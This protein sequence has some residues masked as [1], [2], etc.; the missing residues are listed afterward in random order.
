MSKEK[1]AFP[2]PFCPHLTQG[3]IVLFGLQ[4]LMVPVG[5]ADVSQ[6]LSAVGDGLKRP[7]SMGGLDLSSLGKKLPV[8]QAQLGSKYKTV[9]GAKPDDPDV[10]FA[11]EAAMVTCQESACAFWCA[12]HQGCG[13]VCNQCKAEALKAALREVIHGDQEVSDK[14]AATFHSS[15]DPPQEEAT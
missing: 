12:R 7:A 6:N 14:A 2:K 10:E 3:Q 5:E 8:Y 13:Q 1:Q 11:A 15:G 9:G 4:G